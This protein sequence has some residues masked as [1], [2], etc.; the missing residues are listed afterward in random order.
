MTELPEPEYYQRL[1]ELQYKLEI[2]NLRRDR[3][4]WYRLSCCAL[5]GFVAWKHWD[6]NG[7]A[8]ICLSFAWCLMRFKIDARK[9][10]D[11]QKEL[12]RYESEHS[13]LMAGASFF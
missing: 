6:I 11:A 2:A 3:D 12:E 7:W 4:Y 13:P 1:Y 5:L 8:L 9:V 10:D